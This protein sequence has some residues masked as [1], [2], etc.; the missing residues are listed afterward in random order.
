MGGKDTK[1]GGVRAGVG[2]LCLRSLVWATM[3]SRRKTLFF[4]VIQLIVPLP[5]HELARI[6]RKSAIFLRAKIDKSL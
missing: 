2:G 5:L 3:R 1:R 6:V 4:A